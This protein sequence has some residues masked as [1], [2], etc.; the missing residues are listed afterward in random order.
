MD[1][2]LTPTQQ[3]L[4]IEAII[5][6]KNVPDE[7]TVAQL[8]IVGDRLPRRSQERLRFNQLF[9]LCVAKLKIHN[10]VEEFLAGTSSADARTYLVTGAEKANA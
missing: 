7:D 9:P 2:T 6:N 5:R 10:A 4:N 8:Q 3:F 1:I